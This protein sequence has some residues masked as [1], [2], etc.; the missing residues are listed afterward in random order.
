MAAPVVAALV[1]H[2]AQQEEPKTRTIIHVQRSRISKP[3]RQP[4]A[5]GYVHEAVL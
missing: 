4:V 1:A 3:G 2:K 5:P